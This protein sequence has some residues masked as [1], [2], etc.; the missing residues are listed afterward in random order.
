M[1]QQTRRADM[2]A[3]ERLLNESKV[4]ERRRTKRRRRRRRGERERCEMED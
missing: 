1:K 2:E 3:G 4:G